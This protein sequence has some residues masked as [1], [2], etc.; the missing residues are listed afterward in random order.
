MKKDTPTKKTI[1]YLEHPNTQCVNCGGDGEVR[2][3]D[4]GM[5]GRRYKRCRTCKGEGKIEGECV[6]CD[7]ILNIAMSGHICFNKNCIRFGLVSWVFNPIKK[8]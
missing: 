8:K 2:D 7:A 6:A 3:W 1:D 5:F 4:S